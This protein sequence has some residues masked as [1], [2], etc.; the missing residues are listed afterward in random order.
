MGRMQVE[1]EGM[2]VNKCNLYCVCSFNI[3]TLRQLRRALLVEMTVRQQ[4][5]DD[6]NDVIKDSQARVG[7]S[8]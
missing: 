4:H 8:G 3:A 1:M 2:C 7:A 6:R 5:I